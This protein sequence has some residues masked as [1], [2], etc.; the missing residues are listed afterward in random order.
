METRAV[1]E[2]LLKENGKVVFNE[3]TKSGAAFEQ[4]TK[5]V[6][7]ATN[8]LEGAFSSLKNAIVG[9]GAAYASIEFFKDSED[10]YLGVNRANAE[11]Q[12]SLKSTGAVAGVTN[13]QLNTAAEAAYHSSEYNLQNIKNLQ[14]VLLTFPSVTKETFAESQQAI[15]DTAA[16]LY[17]STADLKTV[18]VQIGKALQDPATGMLTLRREGVNFTKA[19]EKMVAALVASGHKIQAQK[20]I[21]HE[22][23]TEFAGS[24]QAAYNA[25]GAHLQMAKTFEDLQLVTGQLVNELEEDLAPAFLTIVNDIKG[26]VQWGEEHKDLIE[27][28]AKVVGVLAAGFIAYTI[29]VKAAAAADFLFGTSLAGMTVGLEAATV[30]EGEATTAM[31]ALDVA[32]DAN[33]IG[34]AALA[35]T[36]LAAAFLT[37]SDNTDEA[38]NAKKRYDDISD[39]STT[40]L[41]SE[42]SKYN[43]SLKGKSVKDIQSLDEKYIQNVIDQYSAIEDKYMKQANALANSGY[44]STAAYKSALDAMH[45][46]ENNVISNQSYLQRYKSGVSSGTIGG[47]SGIN[48]PS[49]DS[50]KGEKQIVNTWNIKTFADMKVI[51]GGSAE[52]K[53]DIHDHIMTALTTAVNDSEIATGQ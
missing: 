51:N 33:P 4:Q 36:G 2:I 29:A 13:D 16:K 50:V 5:K 3:L 11:I 48:S 47:N 17:G 49:P 46:A 43:L 42:L 39:D 52:S 45:S 6:H 35:V 19:Q 21:L 38:A 31:T 28:T 10:L 7:A 32:M 1:F 12:A 40:A 27:D 9:L 18:T 15:V 30:A 26:A 44:I 22:L 41:D 8:Q 20:Y 25:G 53:G 14:A 34:I 23:E 24:A 37:L